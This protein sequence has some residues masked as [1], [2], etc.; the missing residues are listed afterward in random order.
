M[1]PFTELSQTTLGK[2]PAISFLDQI[3]S[4]EEKRQERKLSNFETHT[5]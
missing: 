1:T 2:A 4:F 5:K 3:A